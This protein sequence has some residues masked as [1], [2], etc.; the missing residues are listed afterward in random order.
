MT[1]LGCILQGG[2]PKPAK[3]VMHFNRDELK[4]LPFTFPKS[5][6]RYSFIFSGLQNLCINWKYGFHHFFLTTCR[7]HTRRCWLFAT[8]LNF[9]A[10]IFFLHSSNINIIIHSGYH[11]I[12]LEIYFYFMIVAFQFIHVLVGCEYDPKLKE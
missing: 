3:P 10:T 8:E 1:L 4:A 2:I 11:T 9:H 5:V 7:K 12:I 6:V